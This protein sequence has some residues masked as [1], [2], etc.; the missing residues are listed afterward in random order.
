MENTKNVSGPVSGQ[1]SSILI[2]NK[3]E[4]E[5]EITEHQKLFKKYDEA[6]NYL[7]ENVAEEIRETIDYPET[8]GVPELSLICLD[9]EKVSKI[10]DELKKIGVELVIKE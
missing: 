1:Q 8:Y 9:E 6:L 7:A 10:K 5:S 3:Y 4:D 2:V